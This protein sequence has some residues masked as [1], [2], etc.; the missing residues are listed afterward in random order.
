MESVAINLGV[1]EEFV[2]HRLA[3]RQRQR[4]FVAVRHELQAVPVQVV[5]RCDAR[6]QP[7]L[8]VDQARRLNLEH[9]VG[10]EEPGVERR[11]LEKVEALG[12]RTQRRRQQQQEHR[13]AEDRIHGGRMKGAD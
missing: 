10:L 13:V 5:T 11:R 9:L 12:R 8:A 2:A 4:D 1:A 3:P 6:L 7:H